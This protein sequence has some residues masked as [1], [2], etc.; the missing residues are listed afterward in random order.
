MLKV[1]TPSAGTWFVSRLSSI[2]TYWFGANNLRQKDL[3][4]HG[5]YN[6]KLIFPDCPHQD[7]GPPFDLSH[8]RSGERICMGTICK[9]L[10]Q[11]NDP[12]AHLVLI[13]PAYLR[14]GSPLVKCLK[15]LEL[16]AWN[17]TAIQVHQLLGFFQYFWMESIARKD[18][19]MFHVTLGDLIQTTGLFMSPQVL[20]NP[21]LTK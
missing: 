16:E 18:A 7:I 3:K 12:I 14:W 6:V 10:K 20:L 1:N 2:V 5:T 13:I 19:K 9:P 17:F 15:C 11:G 21:N 4:A 8:L